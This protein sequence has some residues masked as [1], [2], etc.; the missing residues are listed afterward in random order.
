MIRPAD[1]ISPE[2]NE[3]EKFTLEQR[4]KMNATSPRQE[5]M[6]YRLTPEYWRQ[7]RLDG[8]RIAEDARAARE[9]RERQE[10]IDRMR[11]ETKR[12]DRQTDINCTIAIILSIISVILTFVLPAR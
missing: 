8:I 9:Y 2:L 3:L 7:R 5:Y 12:L 1:P 6:D 10:R 4:A 11:E